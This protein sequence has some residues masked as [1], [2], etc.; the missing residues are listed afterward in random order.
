MRL[1]PI[2]PQIRSSIVAVARQGH[3][4]HAHPAAAAAHA[5]P[6][7]PSDAV[8]MGSLSPELGDVASAR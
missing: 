1:A 5:P 2:T 3:R 6:Q 7:G 8:D 4:R